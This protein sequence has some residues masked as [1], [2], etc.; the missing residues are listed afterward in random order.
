MN[1]PLRFGIGNGCHHIY[2]SN[3]NLVCK[4]FENLSDRFEIVK[5]VNCH[6]D[7]LAACK[8]MTAHLASGG[9]Y[10]DEVYADLITMA[11]AAIAKAEGT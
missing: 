4:V 7:L 2:D 5:A 8:E 6:D 10:K 11:R 9:V 1:K 3:G